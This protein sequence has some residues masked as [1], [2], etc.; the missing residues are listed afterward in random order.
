MFVYGTGLFNSGTR[1]GGISADDYKAGLDMIGVHPVP[2]DAG[3]AG[4]QRMLEGCV[5]AEGEG[6][7]LMADAETGRTDVHQVH[8]DISAA[9]FEC[10]EY[11]A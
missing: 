9:I 7:M 6:A 3:G 1:R 8:F 10:Q 11:P 5:R 4:S 2:D